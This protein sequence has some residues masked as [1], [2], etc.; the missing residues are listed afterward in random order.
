MNS[1][2]AK[3]RSKLKTQIQSSPKSMYKFPE[4]VIMFSQPCILKLSE[5]VARIVNLE[6]VL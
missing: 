2:E 1:D 4:E 6:W 5:R 3:N